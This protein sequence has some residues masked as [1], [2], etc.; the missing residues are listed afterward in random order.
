LTEEREIDAKK[1]EDE[2]RKRG[3][4][5]GC[6]QLFAVIEVNVE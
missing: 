6:G 5:A 2:K 3:R 4:Y 1:I